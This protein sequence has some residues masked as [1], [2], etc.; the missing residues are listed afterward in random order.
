MSKTD[1]ITAALAKDAA[2][3]NAALSRHAELETIPNPLP[4]ADYLCRLSG[5]AMEGAALVE[6]RY[7]PDKLLV[8]EE[9]FGT[10]LAGVDDQDSLEALAAV[11]L[12]DLNNELVPRFLQIR[13]MASR[14]TLDAGHA[15][16]VEDR[17]PRWDN[18]A[19][20]ARLAQL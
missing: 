12:D 9:G 2:D 17:R 18:P 11:I 14:N 7:V 6:L 10:Y 3:L 1:D 8:Q 15:V 13:I 19:L 5:T 16:L 4:R 20:L